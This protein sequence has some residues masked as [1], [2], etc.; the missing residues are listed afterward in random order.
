MSSPRHVMLIIETSKIYGR[1]LLDGI[2]RYAMP[3]GQWSLD[4]EERG[5]D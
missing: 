4:V 1:G 2:G 5:L 3:H